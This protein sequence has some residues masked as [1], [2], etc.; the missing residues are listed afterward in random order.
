MPALQTTHMAEGSSGGLCSEPLN[1]IL[2]PERRRPNCKLSF[3]TDEETMNLHS[4]LENRSLG[5]P[6]KEID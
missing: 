5:P 6:K 1:V 3:N 2:R 4:R